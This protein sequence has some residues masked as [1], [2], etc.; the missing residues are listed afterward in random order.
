MNARTKYIIN[1]IGTACLMV[2]GIIFF[3]LLS[4]P[5]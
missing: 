5:Q 1:E 4:A 3:L 2:G